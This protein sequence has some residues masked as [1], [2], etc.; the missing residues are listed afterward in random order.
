MRRVHVTG[1]AGAGKTT[2]AGKLAALLGV[3]LIGL[4]RVVW[5]EG[6]R[7]AP[8]EERRRAEDEIARRPAW[9]V[10]GVSSTIRSAADTIVFLDVP[11]RVSLA[12]CARR[13]WRYL[14]RSRPELPARCPEVLIVP[15]LVRVIWQFPA[16]MR[17][18]IL[19]D[20]RAAQGRKQL[21]HITSQAQVQDFLTSV[22]RAARPG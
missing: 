22:Q 19:A 16:R 17:P 21:V 6:W 9:V 13:N 12:R 14:F 4:D 5:R 8:P 3:D 15:T 1:N 2:L 20:M 7:P 11:R 10:D 18:R